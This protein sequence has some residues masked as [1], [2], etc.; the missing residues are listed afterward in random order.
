MLLWDIAVKAPLFISIC[1]IC[2]WQFSASYAAAFLLQFTGLWWSLWQLDSHHRLYVFVLQ[3]HPLKNCILCL[4][5]SGSSYVLCQS[6]S[7]TSRTMSW[8][9]CEI[10]MDFQVLR[11]DV[12]TLLCPSFGPGKVLYLFYNCIIKFYTSLLLFFVHHFF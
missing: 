1:C 4:S 3:W 8:P 7:C 12:W 10:A 11:T 5:C 2:L 6:W 9:C